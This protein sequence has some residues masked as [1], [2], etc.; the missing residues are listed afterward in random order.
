MGEAK[1]LQE[2]SRSPHLKSYMSLVSVLDT[3]G[4]LDYF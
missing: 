3:T 4:G 2:Y 1:K